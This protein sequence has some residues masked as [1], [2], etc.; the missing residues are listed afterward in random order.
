MVF[1][2]SDEMPRGMD[3]VYGWVDRFSFSRPMKN[4]A[5]DFS[6]AVLLAEILAQLVPAWVQL[7]NY[8]STLRFQQ[9]L[10]NWETLNRKVL[11]RL[12]CSISHKHQED[13]AN[14]V[15]GAIELLLI[16]VKR[17]PVLVSQER[18]YI[19]QR[20]REYISSLSFFIHN[21]FTAGNANPNE[22]EVITKFSQNPYKRE[23]T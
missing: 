4:P 10:S 5:R 3:G 7:H 18:I 19:D 22:A 17:A 21:V 11:T 12:K 8:P 14:A 9:K 23:F 15:P 20:C 2:R 1:E 13:L 6:D 16:Q